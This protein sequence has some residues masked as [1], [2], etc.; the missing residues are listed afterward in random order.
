MRYISP[1][2]L[3]DLKKKMVFIGGPRQVGKTTLAKWIQ[4]NHFPSGRYF[5]WDYDE[6]RTGILQKKWTTDNKLLI[7]DELHKHPRWKNWIKGIYDVSADNHSFLI[8]GSARLDVHKKGGDS[9][10]GRYH[11]W[12]LHPFTLDEYPEGITKKEAFH[13]LMTV[14]GFPEPFIEG[15]ERSARRWRRERLDRIIREDIRDL[16]SIRNIQI[17]GLFLEMLRNRVGGLITLSNIAEDLQISP[18]TAKMWLEVLERMYLVFPV[19][20]YTNNIPRAVLK[21]P[22]VYFFDNGDVIGDEGARFE[23]LVATSL[24]KRLHFLEDRDGFRYELRYIRDKG[25]RE[26]DFAIIKDGK[27]ESLIEVKYTDDKVSKALAYYAEKLHPENAVQITANL[28]QPYD[29]NNIRVTD[30]LSYFSN[31]F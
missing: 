27:L 21:P 22:K 19:Y 20:P 9:L 24:I 2:I 28:S 3:E 25:G 14:G 11:Y 29:A 5:N 7:F 8:T 12:R 16:E 4:N 15:D 17:I 26:V 30:P 18:K 1:F 13:R 23:N 6:D 31:F 10:A